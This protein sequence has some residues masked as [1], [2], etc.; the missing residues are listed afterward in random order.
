[1]WYTIDELEISQSEKEHVYEEIYNN[2]STEEKQGAV[3]RKAIDNHWYTSVH[4]GH[5]HYKIYKK[6]LIDKPKDIVDEVMMELFGY[7]WEQYFD[8]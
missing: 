4:K 8:E 3:V 6:E 7:N 1:M 5:N 2:L